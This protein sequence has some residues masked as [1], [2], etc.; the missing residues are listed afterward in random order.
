MPKAVEAVKS[1]VDILSQSKRLPKGMDAA[2][3]D[4]A[5]NDLATATSSWAEAQAA[6]AAGKWNEAIDKANRRK[7]RRWRRWE[8]SACRPARS[9]FASR[10]GFEGPRKRALSLLRSVQKPFEKLKRLRMTIRRPYGFSRH[11]HSIVAGGFDVMS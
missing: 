5:K 1:R 8:A 4:A 3:L 10:V 11:S 6:K 2:K 9:D 7:T